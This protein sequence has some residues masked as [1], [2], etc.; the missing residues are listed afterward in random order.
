MNHW[1][2]GALAIVILAV[3]AYRIRVARERRRAKRQMFHCY[4]FLDTNRNYRANS[5]G[6]GWT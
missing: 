4:P 2:Y 5:S 6:R 1:E 3:L